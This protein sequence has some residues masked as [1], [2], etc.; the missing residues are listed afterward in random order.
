[1]KKCRILVWRCYLLLGS[2]APPRRH[3][4][5]R[6]HDRQRLDWEWVINS[7]FRDPEQCGEEPRATRRY[8][9][10]AGRDYPYEIVNDWMATNVIGGAPGAPITI[11]PYDGNFTAKYDA[12]NNGGIWFTMCKYLT[13]T[14][15]E[16]NGPSKTRGTYTIPC[17]S[18]VIFAG[19]SRR[20]SAATTSR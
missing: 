17:R 8:G 20:T 7:P 18:T 13:V 9:V 3:G 5:V 14:G 19:Y 11:A 2:A 12:T 15:L 10:P 6:G 16:F 4:L 1:M